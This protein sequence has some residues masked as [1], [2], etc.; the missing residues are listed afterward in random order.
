MPIYEYRCAQCGHE[1]EELIRNSGE[2]SKLLCPKC[3][4]PEVARRLSVFAARGGGSEDTRLS[5]AGCGKCAE[6]GSCPFSRP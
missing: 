6:Q 2:E 1:F 4:A 3:A 5:G